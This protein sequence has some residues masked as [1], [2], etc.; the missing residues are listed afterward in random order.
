[1]PRLAPYLNTALAVLAGVFVFI[2]AN[3]VTVLLVPAR[4]SKI[5]SS[6]LVVLPNFSLPT[7]LFPT[8]ESPTQD[9]A[10]TTATSTL[11]IPIPEK[12]TKPVENVAKIKPEKTAPTI[13]PTSAPIPVPVVISTPTFSSGNISLDTVASTLRNALVNI[14]CYAPAGNSTLHSISGSGIF[15]DAKGIILTNAHIAQYFLLGDRDVSCTI[16]SGSPATDA[17]KAEL[18]YISP[19]WIHANAGVLSQ[20]QPVGTGEYDF[21]LLAV[22]KSVTSAALPTVFPFT[23]LAQIPPA[24]G[25]PI[26]IASFGAQ[27]LEISQIQSA[28]FPTIVFGSVKDIFTFDINTIDILALGG[29]AAAQEGSSG[30][31]IADASGSLVGTITTSTIEGATDTRSL[32]GITASYVRAEYARETGSLLDSLLNESTASSVTNFATKIPALESILTAQ[33]Q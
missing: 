33:M 5:A 20:A 15:I 29:S 18:I 26:V 30:G 16:R 12:A 32:D 24:K 19:A 7:T 27:F 1:M 31:G 10:T 4:A 2:F 28:L 22:T 6:T 9:R 17:Y 14:I 21:A 23:P 25:T 11:R 13:F 3:N 8:I